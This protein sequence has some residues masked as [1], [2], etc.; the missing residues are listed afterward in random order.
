[1]RW[2]ASCA[3]RLIL[4]QR[5]K[6]TSYH[7]SRHRQEEPYT[8]CHKH[9]SLLPGERLSRAPPSL[10]VVHPA[11]PD[12]HLRND[13]QF[14]KDPVQPNRTT[15]G[16]PRLVSI[17]RPIGPRNETSASPR[18]KGLLDKKRPRCTCKRPAP[19]N[20]T[21]AQSPCSAS[22]RARP[23]AGHRPAV[24]NETTNEIDDVEPGE[25]VRSVSP[26]SAA[27]GHAR[28]RSPVAVRTFPMRSTMVDLVPFAGARMS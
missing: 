7:R 14:D 19:E 1:M 13:V 2:G 3:S 5:W 9:V 21:R 4:C 24:R 23:V 15:A 22:V 20:R 8:F 28:T 6:R 27:T 16:R 11:T 12:P 25:W 18:T 17:T 10:P 26:T